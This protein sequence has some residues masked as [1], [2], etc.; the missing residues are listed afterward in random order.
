MGSAVTISK[1][2]EYITPVTV[3]ASILHLDIDTGSSDL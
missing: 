1:G 3:G 2:M